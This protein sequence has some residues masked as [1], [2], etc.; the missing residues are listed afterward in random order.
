VT[1]ED[2]LDPRLQNASSSSGGLAARW[3]STKRERAAASYDSVADMIEAGLVRIRGADPDEV[4]GRLRG[5]ADGTR[6]GSLPVRSPRGVQKRS[7][8]DE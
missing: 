4:I 2:R 7:G 5:K 3:K 8:E 1:L 6:D